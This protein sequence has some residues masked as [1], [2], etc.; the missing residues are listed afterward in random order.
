VQTFCVRNI[1]DTIDFVRDLGSSTTTMKTTFMFVL[2][3]EK[4]HGQIMLSLEFFKT[5]KVM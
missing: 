4:L 5:A 1:P 2:N 3:E